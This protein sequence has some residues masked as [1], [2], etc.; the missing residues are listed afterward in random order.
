VIPDQLKR[1]D[2]LFV[3]FTPAGDNKN[4]NVPRWNAVDNLRRWDDPELQD[5][6]DHDMVIGCAAAPGSGIVIYDV[7]NR[8][9][10]DPAG[11][12][13]ICH[14]TFRISGYSDERKFKAFFDV[15]D[16]PDEYRDGRGKRTLHGVDVFMPG[17]WGVIAAKG[18]PCWKVG[19][20]CVIPPSKHHTGSRYEI[21]NDI[22]IKRVYW[23]D[24][25]HFYPDEIGGDDKGQKPARTPYI[26]GPDPIPEGYR[27]N[28]LFSIA[29][30]QRERFG[31][32]SDEIHTV[33]SAVNMNRCSPPIDDD[34]LRRIAI[35]ASKYPT[36]S[37]PEG[38]AVGA[39]LAANI[40]ASYECRGGGGPGNEDETP[41][42]RI[43]ATDTRRKMPDIIK[44]IPG[45]LG[46]HARYT[47]TINRM[48]QPQF[49]VQSAL[50]LGSVICG[51]RYVTSRDNRSGLFLMN[52]GDTSSGKK[53]ALD[54]ISTALYTAG[55]THLLIT[56]TYQS[57]E[58]L[59]KELANRITH[60]AT[61]NEAPVKLGL[62]NSP[63][64]PHARNMV[65]R[66]L[67]VWDCPLQFDM[68][69]VSAYTRQRG[70]EPDKIFR[71]SLTLLLA[72]TGDQLFKM[73]NADF[74]SSGFFPRIVASFAD[75]T[76]PA[77]NPNWNPLETYPE[78]VSRWIQEE[79]G[80]LMVGGEATDA[81]IPNLS[82]EIPDETIVPFTDDAEIALDAFGDEITD[83]A[84]QSDEPLV[85]ALLGKAQEIAQ[86]IS[87]IIARSCRSKIIDASHAGWAV[88]YVRFHSLVFCDQVGFSLAEG[89]NQRR[90]LAVLQT[91]KR[92]VDENGY[93]RELTA[94]DLRRGTHYLRDCKLSERDDIISML[95]E[96]HGREIGMRTETAGNGRRTVY[97]RYT[98]GCAR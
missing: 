89:P 60:I 1:D 84:Y 36:D 75:D 71:P 93:Q 52:I 2:L 65:N 10:A 6:I 78:G 72:G 85:R 12:M 94:N 62:I 4:P 30:Q 80:A 97:Y 68:P 27:Y 5:G 25:K 46:E 26:N 7:D 38:E 20:Q 86:R 42:E 49:S 90:V 15:V 32:N 69:K 92:A 44:T 95:V 88:E 77:K 87:L 33:I 3:V 8:K 50:A 16:L 19:G 98:G 63:N 41:P 23:S 64:S 51:R 9:E 53:A 34:E 14:D 79:L 73:A 39:E 76:A 57:A 22:P 67:E 28:T 40:L 45:V 48:I 56:N 66:W 24:I 91:L 70:E 11:I 74:I 61:I 35:S 17:G 58:G 18:E 96:D 59:C 47:D 81:I 83:I 82:T 37:K 13:D 29:C 54:S 55:A 31:F 43:K 21:T